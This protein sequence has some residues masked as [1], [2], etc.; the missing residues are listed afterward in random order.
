MLQN[1]ISFTPLSLLTSLARPS[2]TGAVICALAM[3]MPSANAQEPLMQSQPTTIEVRDVGEIEAVEHTLMVPENRN[4]PESREIALRFVVLPAAQPSGQSPVAYLAGG[5]GG[6]ATG[7]A[8][9]R[10]WPLFDALRQ[11]RDVILLDQRGT[12]RSDTPPVCT[13]SVGWT[14][15][16]IGNRDTFVQKQVAAFSECEAFWLAEGVDLDGYTTQQSAADIAAVSEALGEKLSLLGISYGTHLALAAIKYHPDALDR[17]ALVG[18]E[19][20]DQTVKLPSRTDAYFARLEN[21]LNASRVAAGNE[22]YPALAPA[23]RTALARIERDRPVVDMF[24]ARGRPPIKRTLGA[25]AVQSAIAFSL[26]DPDRADDVAQA[27]L[28]MA[29]DDPDYSFMVFRGFVMP[30]RIRMR[31]MPSIMDIASG[32][33]PDRMQIIEAQAKDALFGDATNFPMPHLASAGSAYVLPPEFRDDPEG[34]TPTLIVS[35]TL[36]GRTYAESAIEA[37]DGLTNRSVLTVENG[38][39]NLFFDHPEVVPSM[40]AFLRGEPLADNHLVAPLPEATA[41]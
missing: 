10:R 30:E 1:S 26:A 25:F 27:I 2:L 39:H 23:L 11:D 16:D 8:Q 37:T 35:G 24:V 36:D 28:A 18:V 15:T 22:P 33:S 3:S 40:V 12:G 9:S 13:S 32:V 34:G 41:R 38:G 14:E 31:A 5:P 4:N 19:G 7:T 17:V 6:S 21:A 20:L 29:A